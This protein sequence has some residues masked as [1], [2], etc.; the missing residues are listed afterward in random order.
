MFENLIY[1]KDYYNS[2]INL[3]SG[4]EFDRTND[5]KDYSELE[6]YN[7]IPKDYYGF[8]KNIIS[9]LV[10]NFDRGTNLRIFG[11]FGHDESDA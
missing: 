3:S 7:N 2:F 11:C 4:A 8:S 1:F 5:I 6:L 10:L 9:K